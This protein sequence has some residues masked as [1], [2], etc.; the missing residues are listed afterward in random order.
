MGAMAITVVAGAK[1]VEATAGLIAGLA[2]LCWAW[3]TWLILVLF[4]VGIW[5]HA[6]HRVP[7]GNA[8]S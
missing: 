7:L 5:R 4:A 8:A 3:A 1:I 6:V 2:I